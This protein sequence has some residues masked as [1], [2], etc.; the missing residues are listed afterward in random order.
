[1]AMTTVPAAHPRS[2]QVA[3]LP[4]AVSV[5]EVERAVNAL[6]ASD[7]HVL[8]AAADLPFFFRLP[9]TVDGKATRFWG[10][11]A[12]NRFRALAIRHRW[13]SR[14]LTRLYVETHVRR[15]LHALRA[16]LL[17]ELLGTTD[18]DDRVRLQAI[19]SEL[20]NRLPP[21]LG[22]RR[23]AA[24]VSRLPALAAAVPV[25]WAASVLPLDGISFASAGEAL[26]I[27]GLGALGV[28]VL[29]VWPAVK[30]GFRV[31]R[32]IFAG[33]RDKAH[34]FLDSDDEV[35]WPRFEAASAYDA[36][37]GAFDALERR[38]PSELPLDML[39]S[40]VPYVAFAL[41]GLMI[42]G[43]AQAARDGFEGFTWDMI[44]G[45]WL[46]LVILL[47]PIAF[48]RNARQNYANRPH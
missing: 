19:E 14:P 1:M 33:G 9:V 11:F 37:S 23:L 3:A 41:M 42:V 45:S 31:K 16:C 13:G 27:V 5:D 7:K 48:V 38:K 21:L 24:I 8:K 25:V 18:E 29:V 28:W 39:L 2:A 10:G 44:G 17:L 22:W 6:L 35:E 46:V 32:A 36:E 34:L 12:P 43:L 26:L 30:L 20:S 47:L 40:F 15:Q 4:A